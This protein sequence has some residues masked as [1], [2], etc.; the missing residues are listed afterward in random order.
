[1]K[2]MERVRAAIA[3][4][5]VDRPPASIWKHFPEQDQTAE[6]L[7][8]E[9]VRWQETYNWD[10]VKFM[11]PG[12]YPTIDWGGV[13]EFKGRLRGNRTT[14]RPALSSMDELE[15]LQPVDVGAGFYGEM[16]E[17]LRRSRERI[18]PDVPF[19]HTIFSP[20]TIAQKLL[21]GPVVEMARSTPEQLHTGLKVITDVTGALVQASFDAGADGIFF[22]SQMSTRD[23]VAEEDYRTFGLPYD[24]QLLEATRAA[25]PESIVLMHMHGEDPM[26][27]MAGEYPIDIINWHD[28]SVG[29][30]VEVGQRLSGKAVAGGINER[31]FA[32]APAG[33]VIQEVRDS[34]AVNGGRHILLTPGCGIPHYTSEE[35]LLEVA[36]AI[37]G[38][39]GD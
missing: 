11:P 15:A 16:T 14:V 19:L 9:T 23:L 38:H 27:A 30:P 2:P 18:D 39:K 17:A 22:A 26:L 36:Q 28:R 21:D 10:F 37:Q 12:D 33:E 35:R 8:R 6:D 31:A 32:D 1:M 7:A 5:D 25:K 29:P 13:T 3:N 34:M 24:L 20:L 4:A